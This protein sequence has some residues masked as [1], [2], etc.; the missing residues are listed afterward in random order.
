MTYKIMVAGHRIVP[1]P[2]VVALELLEFVQRELDA[3]PDL[4]MISGM[5]M[6]TDTIFAQIARKL[7]VPLH[8]YIPFPKQA[9]RWSKG[10]QK[11]HSEL[12]DYASE[13]VV[14]CDEYTDTAYFKR[15]QSMVDASAACVAVWGGETRSG[16]GNAVWSARHKGI[17][18]TIITP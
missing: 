16:T 2:D 10:A 5:A 9:S 12:L 3:H 14:V 13:S 6:G 7:G 18:V 17:D 8:A 11:M 4:V 15:N 1:R